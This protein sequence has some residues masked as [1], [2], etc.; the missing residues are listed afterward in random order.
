MI[1][2]PT[3]FLCCLT[4][5]TNNHAADQDPILADAQTRKVT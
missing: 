2:V 1:G 3:Y 4:G 5:L